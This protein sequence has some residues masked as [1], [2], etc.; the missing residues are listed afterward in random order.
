L[1]EEDEEEYPSRGSVWK[2]LVLP[3]KI[4]KERGRLP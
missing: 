3:S 1:G 2:K 4:F